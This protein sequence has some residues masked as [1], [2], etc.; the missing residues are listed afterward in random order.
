[1]VI[2]GQNDDRDDSGHNGTLE[3]KLVEG[4]LHD[5]KNRGYTYQVQGRV[6]SDSDEK[7]PTVTQ[8]MGLIC[9]LRGTGSTDRILAAGSKA[10]NTS[11]H[12]HHPEHS[13]LN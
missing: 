6:S 12:D 4:S 11:S 1:M 8:A 3:M 9:S 13:E 5:H 10:R 7:S 2:G